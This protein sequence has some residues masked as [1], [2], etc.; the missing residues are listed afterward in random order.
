MCDKI[1]PIFENS[2]RSLCI[3]IV[4]G[5]IGAAFMMAGFL[6]PSN[7]FSCRYVAIP[8]ILFS[9]ICLR[10]HCRNRHR[11]RPN[12]LAAHVNIAMEV[13]P[14]QQSSSTQ[15][16]C[17]V[18]SN[19]SS[20]TGE[21][22]NGISDAQNQAYS[23]GF[24]NYSMSEVA[25]DPSVPPPPPPYNPSWPGPQQNVSGDLPP[26]P[27]NSSWPG[28]QQNVSADLPPPPCYEEVVRGSR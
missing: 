11:N 10:A 1:R 13:Q 25:D 23:S 9:Y 17:P 12:Q 26:P 14:V 16:S 3:G 27:Y 18:P 19:L 28:T 5:M 2:A 20:S 15:P 4:F 6:G 21:T 22:S 24:A 7:M 8:F